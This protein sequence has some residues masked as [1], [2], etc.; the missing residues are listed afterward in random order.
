MSIP[1]HPTNRVLSQA[2]VWWGTMGG[3]W[4]AVA[5]WERTAARTFAAVVFSRP[6]VYFLRGMGPWCAYDL[7]QQWHLPG[8]LLTP[9]A[10]ALASSHAQL[11][12]APHAPYS[13]MLHGMVQGKRAL[14][15][16]LVSIVQ[17]CHL[18]PAHRAHAIKRWELTHDTPLHTTV[19]GAMTMRT[20]T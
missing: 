11:Y 8:G 9:G 1:Y 15:P 13:C 16:Q 2:R 20:H 18:R 14:S 4:E 19:H 12:H 5:A 6:D 7:L 10:R 17:P 3:A